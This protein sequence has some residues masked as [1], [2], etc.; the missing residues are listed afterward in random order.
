[1]PSDGE[2][3]TSRRFDSGQPVLGPYS[4]LTQTPPDGAVSL[5][6]NC[7]DIHK[8]FGGV[9]ALVGASLSAAAGEVHALVGEN[10]AGKSTLIKTLGGRL[11]P[12]SG[13][14]EIGGR[15]VSFFQPQDAHV[16]GI[17]TV[18]QEL[19]L[20]PWMTVAENLLLG[21]EPRGPLGLIHRRRMERQADALLSRLGVEHVDPL[22]LVEDLSLAERQVIEIVRSIDAKPAILLLDEPTSSLVEREVRWL[23]AQIRKLRDAGVCIVFTSHRWNEI[24]D[25][26]DR[27]TIFR[28]GR[29]V[30]TFAEIDEGDA[31]TL[32]TGRRVEALYPSLSPV[33]GEDAA[34]RVE[35]LAGRRVHDV[36]LTLR[37]GEVLGVGGLAGHGHRELFFQLFGAERIASGSVAVDGRPVRLRSPRDAVRRGVALALVPEDRKG[38]GLLL[39]VSVRNNLSLSILGRVSRAGVLRFGY[40]R[41]LTQDIVARL[42]VRT[43]SLG[44][45]VSA[46]SG[47]NQQKVLIGRWLLAQP[48]ILLLYDVT[49]GVDVATKHELYELIVQLAAQGHSILFYSSDAEE[50]ARLSHRVLVMREGRVAAELEQ[51]DVTAES[52]VAAAVRD[53]VNV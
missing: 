2:A 48:R 5:A 46:L 32:M 27:I 29:H 19:T 11:R 47:G 16:Y 24:R 35:H 26:A 4:V 12:D 6:F 22:A 50:L 3:S 21:R 39:A 23:F 49:R 10:G 40:E 43:P 8:A 14:I 7:V 53:S 44:H 17:R 41:R 42:K 51:P 25:I 33:P 31:V 36:S 38:E 34:L 15:S 45:P 20:L 37:R 9:Q 30:G 28:G 18:F 13:V 52:I 1:L